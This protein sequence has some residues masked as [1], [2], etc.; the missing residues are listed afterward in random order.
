MLK[1]K[2]DEFLFEI[3]TKQIFVK[4]FDVWNAPEILCRIDV[5]FMESEK[6]VSWESETRTKRDILLAFKISYSN[7]KIVKILFNF[8]FIF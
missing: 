8:L 6:K 2:C 7:L 1:C 5:E 3:N 4:V